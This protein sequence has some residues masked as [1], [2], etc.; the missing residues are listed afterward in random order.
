MKLTIRSDGF[1]GYK[2]RALARARKLDAKELIEPEMTI[3]FESAYDML[4]VL[5]PERVR[6]CKMA[7]TKPYSVSGLAAALNRDPKSVR[8]DIVKLESFGVLRTREEINPG[9]GRVKIVEPVA[10]KFELRS[11]F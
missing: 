5:Q 1:E 9:H 10:M 3:N 8:R 2:E 7:R 6:L 4:E 11:S